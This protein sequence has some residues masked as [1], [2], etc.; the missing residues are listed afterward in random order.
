MFPTA[1]CQEFNQHLNSLAELLANSPSAFGS[2]A[3][4]HGWINSPNLANTTNGIQF[5]VFARS[6]RDS[7]FFGPKAIT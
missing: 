2:R 4:S 6:G 5:V 1:P 7:H 3:V